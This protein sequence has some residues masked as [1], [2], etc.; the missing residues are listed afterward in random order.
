MNI[1]RSNEIATIIKNA[2]D[3]RIENGGFKAVFGNA[4]VA[5]SFETK[6]STVF[7]IP[8]QRNRYKVALQR[9]NRKAKVFRRNGILGRLAG[10]YELA[11]ITYYS[12]PRYK[13][14]H[15]H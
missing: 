2:K 3:I 7:E 10:L 5:L 1:F 8:I 9:G 14:I 6:T 15:F 13:N 4:S 11:L 12:P